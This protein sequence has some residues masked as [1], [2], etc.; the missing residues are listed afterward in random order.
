[1]GLDAKGIGYEKMASLVLLMGLGVTGS[2]SILL[3][4]SVISTL[5][6]KGKGEGKTVKKAE[7]KEKRSTSPSSHNDDKLEVMWEDVKSAY[8]KVYG[9]HLTNA[10]QF[11][12]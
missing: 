10:I 7:K 8:F 6:R 12:E 11:S 2:V 1:L 5:T 4:E 9:M 3:L